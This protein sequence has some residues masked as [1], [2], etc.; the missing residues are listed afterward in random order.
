MHIGLHHNRVEGAVDP[1]S[2]LEDLGEER[3][4]A[5]LWDL[6]LNITGLGRE[7]AKPVSVAVVRAVI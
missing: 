6:E 7:Q 5:K 1:T 4:T 2:T 3:A